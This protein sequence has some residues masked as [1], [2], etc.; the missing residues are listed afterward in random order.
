[1]VRGFDNLVLTLTLTLTQTLRLSIVAYVHD[2]W[3]V[4]PSD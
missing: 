1:M 2:R 4:E 3:T